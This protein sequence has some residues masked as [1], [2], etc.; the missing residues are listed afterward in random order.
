MRLALLFAVTASVYGQTTLKYEVATIKPARP[1]AVRNR[2]LYPEPDRISIPSMSLSWLIYTAYAEGMGT[3]YYVGGGPDWIKT[4]PYAIEA[5]APR[6][7]TQR[8]R[9]IMLRALL[10]ERFHLKFHMQKNTGDV[11]ALMLDGPDRKLGPN[12]QEWDGTCSGRP[13][14]STDTDDP[15]TPFCQSG[16]TPTRA[17]IEGGTMFSAAEV[18]SLPLS[19]ALVGGVLQ[20]RTGL[21]GR[22]K[23]HL[24]FQ[25]SAPRPTDPAAPPGFVGPTIFQAI[26]EQWGMRIEKAKGQFDALMV[27][28]AEPPTEN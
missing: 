16:L 26:R 20:D 27:D 7:A 25:F 9:R 28:S 8:E 24:D 22:Y 14:A 17:L 15:Y 11:Y 19:R 18:L 21:K 1:D 5:K 12:I 10:E 23:M 3:G 2:V 13:P 6:A 4:T